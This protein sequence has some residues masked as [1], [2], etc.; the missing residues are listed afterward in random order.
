M[1]VVAH[2][3]VVFADLKT[4][5]E[6]GLDVKYHITDVR[7]CLNC[8]GKFYIIANKFEKNRGL[9]LLE[10]DE[11]EPCKK[12]YPDFIIKSNVSLE[13]GDANLFTLE[14]TDRNSDHSETKDTRT[15]I[16]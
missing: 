11:N 3:D 9:Y 14:A 5:E 12:S 1:L 15:K 6:V 2:E 4:Q 16:A 13:I 8:Y 10:L 7:A